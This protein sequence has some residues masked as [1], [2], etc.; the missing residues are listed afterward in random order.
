MNRARS[1]LDKQYKMSHYFEIQL[2]NQGIGA[3]YCSYIEKADT[4]DKLTDQYLLETRWDRQDKKSLQFREH[5]SADIVCK[6]Q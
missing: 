2:D 1:H 5:Y 4:A 3:W 6:N